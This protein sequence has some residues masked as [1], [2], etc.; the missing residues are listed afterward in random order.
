MPIEQDNSDDYGEREMV[1]DYLD[2]L[3]D[4]GLTNMFGAGP[5]VQREFGLDK[6]TARAYLGE[7]MRT[8]ASRHPS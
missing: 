5:Y 2:D 7:W 1:F 4:S 8:F 6:Q 3:R